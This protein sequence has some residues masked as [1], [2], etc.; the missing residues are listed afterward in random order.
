[1]LKD[2]L[3]NL[4]KVEIKED[5]VSQLMDVFESE[6]VSL[7]DEN[8]PM[9]PSLCIEEFRMFLEETIDTSLVVTDRYIKFGVGDERKLGFDE[10]LDKNTTDCVKIIG[11]ILQGISGEYVLVTQE[12][13]K[14]MFPKTYEGDLGR[15]G[16]AYLMHREEYDRG[17]ELRGWPNVPSWKFS[18]FA[19]IPGF[20]DKIELDMEKYIKKLGGK[21]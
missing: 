6:I 21:R 12:M 15:T 20:F 17:V 9:K 10:D 4:I 19:G 18:N 13:A 1:M 14:K 16:T 3:I 11:T 8:D 7:E 5:I 2:E